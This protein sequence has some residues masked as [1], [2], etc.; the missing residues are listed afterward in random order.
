M[1]RALAAA[2][3]LGSLT[4]SLTHAASQAPNSTIG[5][6]VPTCLGPNDLQVDGTQSSL[7]G[8]QT[9]DH[10]CVEHHG[11]LLA[12]RLHLRVGELYVDAT[13]S[14]QADGGPGSVSATDCDQAG[15]GT[16]TGDPGGTIV[17]DA[18]QATVLGTISAAGG[19][20]LAVDDNPADNGP[21]T[22]SQYNGGPGGPG[23]TI[24]IRAARL[25]LEGTIN[26][27]GGPGGDV[28]DPAGAPH[29]NATGGGPGGHG[30]TATMAL[31]QPLTPGQIPHVMASGGLP[32]KGKP[33]GLPGHAGTVTLSALTAAEAVALPP[34][35]APLGT[36][37]N[38]A[39]KWQPIQS[40]SAFTRGM[41]CGAGDLNLGAHTRRTLSGNHGYTHIC[42]HDG[43]ILVAGPTLTL[44]A[45]T[46]YVDAR[47]RIIAN[48][49]AKRTG[50]ATGR[51]ASAGAPTRDAR[52]PH[53]GVAGPDG[54]GSQSAG[55][56]P[57]P[58]NDSLGGKGGGA[59][60]LLAQRILLAGPVSANGANG[61][62]GIDGDCSPSGCMDYFD[63]GSGGSGG[64]ILV[65]AGD[66]QLTG[67]ISVL[68]GAGG[69][70]G[71][72]EQYSANGGMHGGPGF[73]KIF[74]TTL[75]AA[76]SLPINGPWVLGRR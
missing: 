58:P 66:L 75:R 3:L 28:S 22:A 2:L 53:P 49:S 7:Q 61:D 41:A 14:I 42:L 24:T 29:G 26:A 48:G 30:G 36:V 37:L 65:R 74:A 11:I 1:G 34:P 59:I 13:S 43:A 5:A 62:P 57:T 73:V 54:S 56:S 15:N 60:S 72:A 31:L 52:P 40:L 9:F 16:P 76:R 12:S 47:S 25:D 51:Y 27:A 39:P 32:G 20:G 6:P 35:P 63:G 68:G 38:P 70:P 33:L 69:A 10:V 45:E 21:C 23:G 46:I 55:V 71:T 8:A 64:G 19:S 50:K 18:R 44:H 17:I 4:V 67:T